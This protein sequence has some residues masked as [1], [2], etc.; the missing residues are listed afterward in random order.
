MSSKVNLWEYNTYINTLVTNNNLNVFWNLED[1]GSKA[2]EL[3][4]QEE[5]EIA[6]TLLTNQVLANDY[7]LWE[8]IAHTVVTS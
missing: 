8:A 5:N 2:R 6:N 3:L 1:L 7:D 4:R